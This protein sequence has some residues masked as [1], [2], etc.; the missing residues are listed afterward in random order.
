MYRTRP[1]LRLHT[2][3]MNSLVSKRDVLLYMGVKLNK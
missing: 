3:G 2:H 1:R